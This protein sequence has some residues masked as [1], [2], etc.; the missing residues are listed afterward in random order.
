MTKGERWVAGLRQDGNAR[1]SQT[2]RDAGKGLGAQYCVAQS[3][4]S[5]CLTETE[6][7]RFGR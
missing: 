6:S 1:E 5:V 7:V 2:G 3:S 4:V